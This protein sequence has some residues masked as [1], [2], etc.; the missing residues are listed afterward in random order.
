M[1]AG[2]IPASVLQAAVLVEMFHNL[3]RD[4]RRRPSG[5][6]MHDLDM[7]ECFCS[8]DESV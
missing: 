8:R 4:M 7:L 6:Q 5:M 3:G 2:P 1:H